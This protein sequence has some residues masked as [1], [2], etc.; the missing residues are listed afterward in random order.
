MK[1]IYMGTPDFAVPALQSL[2]DAGHEVALVVSQEDRPKGRG[3]KLQPTPVK[4]KA[5]ELGL[6][7]FQPKNINTEDSIE[8]IR[9]I[10]PD[11]IIVAAYGQILKDDVLNAPKY[12]CLNIHASLLPKYRGAA[13]INWVII[14]G[15]DETGVTIMEMERGLDTG[16]MII[17]ESIP[18]LEED[19]AVSLYDKLSNMGGKLI[20]EGIDKVADGFEGLKQ[21]DEKSTYASMLSKEMGVIDWT[22]SAKDI[23]NLSRG[24]KPWP[25]AYTNYG[26]EVV[27]IHT[28]VVLDSTSKEVPGTILKVDKSGMEVATG[29]GVLLVTE[30]QFPNKKKMAVEDYIKGNDIE[31]KTMLK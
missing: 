21:D 24:L 18:I 3:K 11:F 27:K 12:K 19:D 16:D 26:E 25:T 5:L 8:K 4:E 30:L 2:H 28:C 7:V 6:E 13:P 9:E 22:K 23:R 20:L 29:D 10:N 31:V 1:I 15:E 17:W 14:N